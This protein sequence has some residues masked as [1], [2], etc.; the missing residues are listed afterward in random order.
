MARL[1]TKI[2]N[3][4]NEKSFELF[5]KMLNLFNSLSKKLLKKIKMIQKSNL[6]TNYQTKCIHYN[7]YSY[8]A[9]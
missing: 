1:F 3:T 9:A 6:S 8:L 2:I 5:I 7:S 4:K